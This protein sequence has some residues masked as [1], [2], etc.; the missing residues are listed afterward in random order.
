M[1][2]STRGGSGKRKKRKKDVQEIQK[3]RTNKG[4][5][6]TRLSYYQPSLYLNTLL[7]YNILMDQTLVPNL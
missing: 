5:M 2:V 7:K 4:H 3:K 1:C 6:M